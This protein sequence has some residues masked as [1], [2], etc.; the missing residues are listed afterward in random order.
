LGCKGIPDSRLSSCG[1]GLN[2]T[3]STVV[4]TCPSLGGPWAVNRPALT[5]ACLA[6]GRGVP[7][8]AYR[9][10]AER[11]AAVLDFLRVLSK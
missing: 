11:S 2:S 3:I 5:A 1:F 9:G 8:R 4:V 10:I 6:L 7:L